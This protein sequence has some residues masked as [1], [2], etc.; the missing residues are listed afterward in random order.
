MLE[1]TTITENEL[2]DDLLNILEDSELVNTIIENVKACTIGDDM[3]S[4]DEFKQLR[5][6]SDDYSADLFYLKMVDKWFNLFGSKDYFI[7]K[8]TIG[9]Y[10]DFLEFLSNTV[11]NSE[12]NGSMFISQSNALVTQLRSL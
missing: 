9:Q 10:C 3:S 8:G 7:K 11:E 2:H 6:H 1:D 12:Y 4:M 5:E